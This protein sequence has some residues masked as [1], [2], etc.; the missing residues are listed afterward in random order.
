MTAPTLAVPVARRT[1]VAHYR[2]R[3]VLARK[4]L[5]HRLKQLERDQILLTDD[6]GTH[7]FGTAH[8]NDAL[9]V[10]AEVRHPHVYGD[11]ALGGPIAAGETYINGHWTTND[12]TALL[13]I[14]LR[15]QDVFFKVATGPAKLV[16][17]GHRLWHWR[18]RNTV[19][20]SKCNIAAHYDLGND[21][22]QLFLDPTMMYSS[23]I[24]PTSSSTLEEASVA[25]LDI[26]GHKL[27][28]RPTDHLL[29][30]GTG[31][32]GLALHVAKRFGCRVTTTTI[33]QQQYQLAQA[34][35]RAAGLSDRVQ[36]LCQDYRHL[37]G[38]FDKI[39]SVEMIEA[40]GHEYLDTFFQRCRQLL[41]PDGMLLL[42]AITMNDAGYN[43]YRRH[44]DFIQRYIFPGG[45]LPSIGALSAAVARTT[46]LRW[47]HMEDFGLHYARTL[48]YWRERLAQQ[49]D[50]A[51]ALG[52]SADFLR[53]FAYYFSYC[54]AGFLERHIHLHHI[55]L[56]GPRY[57]KNLPSFDAM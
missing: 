57:R 1:P 32:G 10:Q 40:V 21:F 53:M 46:D 29:E 43:H 47:S 9:R 38:Q 33:S 2:G 45:C 36:V 15:N 48:Q 27:Q 6:T 25:K 56:T 13:R 49:A 50:Q 5:F 24:F 51:L 39:V 55:L 44:V 35:V 4:A 22:Y 54:E 42:Q 26:I 52:Y 7:T 20:G 12:L 11:L 17:W 23:A 37:T 16:A 30:I 31:W 18:H 8:A 3:D 41:R 19:A 34:R 28:L 14:A